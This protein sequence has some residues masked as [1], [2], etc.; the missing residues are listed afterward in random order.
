MEKDF[1]LRLLQI[2][3]LKSSNT[4]KTQSQLNFNSRS[5]STQLNLNS[6]QPQLKLLSLAQLRSSLF[7]FLLETFLQKF[8]L[9]FYQEY[10]T[11]FNI[12][13][14]VEPFFI[15]KTLLQQFELW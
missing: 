1:N 8:N 2:L 11:S 14:I 4:C 5:A 7:C 10:Y 3:Q 12:L 13:K 6:T 15:S 9:T